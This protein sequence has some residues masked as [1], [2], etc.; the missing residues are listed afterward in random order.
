MNPWKLQGIQ[1]RPWGSGKVWFL[2]VVD[3]AKGD[4]V[5]GIAGRGGPALSEHHLKTALLPV[6]PHFNLDLIAGRHSIVLRYGRLADEQL[7]FSDKISST[8]EIFDDGVDPVGE[9][10]TLH[11][12]FFQCLPIKGDSGVT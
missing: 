2:P 4:G 11:S 8:V 6:K 1:S 10:L 12:P 3:E 9:K 7:H 5:P